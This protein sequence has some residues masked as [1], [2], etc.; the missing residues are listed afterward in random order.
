M[1]RGWLRKENIMNEF[2]TIIAIAVI[3]CVV[4][5][6]ILVRLV[7]APHWR[8]RFLE[9][10]MDN[11]VEP[12]PSVVTDG[13]SQFTLLDETINESLL[14]HFEQSVTSR[15]VLDALADKPGALREH[16]VVAVLNRQLAD[17]HKRPLP[18]A[19]V[20]RIVMILMGSN[21]VRLHRGRLEITEAGKRLGALL[22]A[23]TMQRNVAGSA[24][25]SP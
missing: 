22:H 24:F 18:T 1:A 3:V 7:I 11:L 14:R 23:R 20:R 17:G 13:E 15:K 25:V 19:V 4:A 21:L 9:E 2:G 6:D 16:E 8:D 12:E 5:A 10:L